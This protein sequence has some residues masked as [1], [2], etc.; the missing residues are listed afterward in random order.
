MEQSV[1]AR[2]TRAV[3]MPRLRVEASRGADSLGGTQFQGT[4]GPF[5]H[6]HVNLSPETTGRP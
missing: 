1:R 2:R 4:S 6:A 5:V 3:L